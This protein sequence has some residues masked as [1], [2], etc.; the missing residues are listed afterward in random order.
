MPTNKFVEMLVVTLD[1]RGLMCPEPILKAESAIGEI[2]A[3]SELLVLATDPAAPIDFEVWC[4]H[5]GHHY[6]GS[7]NTGQWLE[8][9]LRKKTG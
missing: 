7:E 3:G 2:D 1:T 6:I 5:K 8:I 4:Q 9:S